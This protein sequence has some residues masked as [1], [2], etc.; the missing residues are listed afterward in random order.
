LCGYS[1]RVRQ[2]TPQVTIT[3]VMTFILNY[4]NKDPKK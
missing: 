2:G 3:R 4:E 1:H